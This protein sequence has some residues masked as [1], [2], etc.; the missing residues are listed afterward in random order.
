MSLR[1]RLLLV[2]VVMLPALAPMTSSAQTTIYESR[3]KA[4]PVFSDR[5]MAGASAIQPQAPNVVSMPAPPGLPPQAPAAAAPPY[6]SIAFVSLGDGA[7]V[8]SNTG[9]FG[10]GVRSV[11]PLRAGDQY[12]ITLDGRMLPASFRG[13]QLKVTEADWRNAAREESNEHTLRV[14][15]VDAQGT[16]LI[17]TDPITFYVQRAAVGGARN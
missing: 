1:S 9:A 11:P 6:R 7:T 12:R 8:H 15:I 2:A 5:P 3:D 10:F 13:T 16:V 17:M 4:G 14:G